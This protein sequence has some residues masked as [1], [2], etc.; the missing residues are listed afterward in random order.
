MG[1]SGTR[2]NLTSE[3][4]EK[5]LIML[6]EEM[7]S[8]LAEIDAYASAA[9]ELFHR[10]HW[11]LPPGQRRNR[12]RLSFILML[13]AKTVEASLTEIDARMSVLMKLGR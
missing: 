10:M 2:R 5:G 1:S 6:L 3:S 7:R 13:A 9:D 11:K 12:N 8:R 4:R